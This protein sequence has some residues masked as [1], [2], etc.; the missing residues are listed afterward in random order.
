[1]ASH[2]HFI[3]TNGDLIHA[4]MRW[5]F[6]SPE[7]AKWLREDL[8]ALHSTFVRNL[9]RS[10]RRR[11]LDPDEAAYAAGCLAS[12][13]HGN[14]LLAP[15]RAPSQPR[16]EAGGTSRRVGPGACVPQPDA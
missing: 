10:I 11:T 3:E 5:L 12:L 4:F 1:V 15:G 9:E 7:H 2:A 14:M 16:V 6:S 8:M 13:L